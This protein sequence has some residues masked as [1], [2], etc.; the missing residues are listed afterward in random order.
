MIYLLY[1]ISDHTIPNPFSSK[2]VLMSATQLSEHCLLS[3][4]DSNI[5][6]ACLAILALSSFRGS[7]HGA[8][9]TVLEF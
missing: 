9:K 6:Y 1:I 7:F 8:F 5:S 3:V 4:N 2:S